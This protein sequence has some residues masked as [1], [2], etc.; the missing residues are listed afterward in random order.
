MAA[1]A[2]EQAQQ[3]DLAMMG[4]N[5][6]AAVV[7]ASTNPR[8]L[9][10]EELW[11]LMHSLS[12]WQNF[13]SR[14]ELSTR[15]GLGDYADTVPYWESRALNFYG[16]NPAYAAIWEDLREGFI[17]NWKWAGVVDQE[18][19]TIEHNSNA[20]ATQRWRSTIEKISE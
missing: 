2:F 20:L 1:R 14:L 3:Y 10:D 19:R 17:S 6:A 18:F 9:S 5:P 15:A 4:E 8:E 12:F 11:M 16:A 13:D 7:K